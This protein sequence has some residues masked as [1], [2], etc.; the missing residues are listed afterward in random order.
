MIARTADIRGHLILIREHTFRIQITRACD[1]IFHLGVLPCQLPAD[2]M[3]AVEEVTAV[4]NKVIFLDLPPGRFDGADRS[5]FPLGHR[6]RSDTGSRP[7]A[8]TQLIK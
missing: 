6:F 3:T 2:Q 4:I 5:A 8:A 7:S 1:E